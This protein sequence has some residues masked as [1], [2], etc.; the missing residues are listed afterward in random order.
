MKIR[1]IEKQNVFGGICYFILCNNYSR[2]QKQFF[3]WS[4][5][6]IRH[7][8]YRPDIHVSLTSS[9]IWANKWFMD[10]WQY[11]LRRKNGIVGATN[12][13]KRNTCKSRGQVTAAACLI[14]STRAVFCRD[15]SGNCVS[16][17]H[18]I[19]RRPILLS[20]KILLVFLRTTS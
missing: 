15:L 13:S 18:D 2:S 11:K 4:F 17:N 12:G 19:L 6:L 3:L 9:L 5:W 7:P 14:P 10:A 1:C 20:G 8:Y 16:S